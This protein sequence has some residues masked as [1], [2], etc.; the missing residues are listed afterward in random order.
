MFEHIATIRPESRYKN[1]HVRKDHYGKGIHATFGVANSGKDQLQSISF[2]SIDY[3]LDHVN[4][5]MAKMG[6]KKKTIK[7]GLSLPEEFEG[8]EGVSAQLKITADHNEVGDREG[9][10]AEPVPNFSMVAYNGGVMVT[11]G[12]PT[13]LVVNL[14][15]LDTRGNMKIPILMDHKTTQ[16]VGHSTNVQKTESQITASGP[17]S[18]ATK[19]SKEVVESSANGYPW[20]SS[21]GATITKARFLGKKQS[22]VVNGKTVK[23]PVLIVDKSVLKEISFVSIGADDST[24]AVAA[25]AASKGELEMGFEAWLKAK[26]MDINALD[27]ATKTA[28]QAMY[29]AE[30]GDGDQDTDDK[31]EKPSLKAN[32]GDND[33]DVVDPEEVAKNVLKAERKR[34]VEIK[35]A[36]NG[37]YP[38]IQAKAESEGWSVE[39]TNA[40]VIKAIRENRPNINVN[41]GYQ[42]ED[43]MEA[44]EAAMCMRAGHAEKGLVEEYGEKVMEAAYKDRGMGIRD[45][46]A[47]AM[48][49]EGIPVPRSMGN[50]F[51]RAAISTASLPGLLGNVANKSLLKSYQLQNITATTVCSQ[52]D[53]SD[54]K[55]ATRFRLNELGDYQEVPISGELKHGTLGEESATNQLRTYGKMITLSRE[56]IINDDLSSLSKIP[57]SIGAR[58]AQKIDEVFYT[59]LLENP[60]F[61]SSDALF[62]SANSNFQDGANTAL[63]VGAM[64]TAMQ[65]FMDQTT[66]D[67]LP[68]NVAARFLLVPTSLD[69]TARQVMT[70]STL[71]SVGNTDATDLVTANPL[72]TTGLQIVTSPFLNSQNI[73]GSSSLAWYLFGDPAVVDTFEIGYLRGQRTPVLEQVELPSNMLG[74]GWRSWF[75][76]GIKEQDFRGMIKSKGE[77]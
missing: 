31:D 43:N 12:I 56:M 39:K 26:G 18:A 37:E 4:A 21:I 76:F 72:L 24:S 48:R 46:M 50:D 11:S 27:D 67:G 47:A 23:G 57:A 8:S 2:C 1:F 38:D 55:E 9:E 30:T 64:D 16:R 52:G 7:A 66:I 5:F 17:V 29:D 34:Y 74:M 15:G 42:G 77:A 20:Q 69:F 36:C 41:Q 54:F 73:S 53:L 45:V 32:A 19:F 59:R 35:E 51:I 6:N 22:E 62:S 40:E 68:I 63:S 13:P 61:P 10:E 70:S 71:M 33:D 14:A 75:D 49:S 65:L 3:S 60:N 58:A 25:S 44:L 28:L